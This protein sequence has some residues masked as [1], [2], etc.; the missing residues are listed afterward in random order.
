MVFYRSLFI[1]YP[2]GFWQATFRINTINILEQLAANGVL[3]NNRSLAVLTYLGSAE[4]PRLLQAFFMKNLEKLV[5]VDCDLR[6]YDLKHL[7]QSCR[8]LIELRI[9]QLEFVGVEI[10]QHLKKALRQGFQRLQI[11]E[12]HFI[13]RPHSWPVFQEIV[14]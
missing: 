7:F 2:D 11:C 13:I 6:Q 10:D 1:K 3:T 12:M 8:K 9:K 14:T 4:H 5:L